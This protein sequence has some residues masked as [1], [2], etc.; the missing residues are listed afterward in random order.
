MFV[1]SAELEAATQALTNIGLTNDDLYLF[2]NIVEEEEEE[3]KDAIK[4]AL[5]EYFECSDEKDKKSLNNATLK[6]FDAYTIRD[7][8]FIHKIN[9]VIKTMCKVAAKFASPFFIPTNDVLLEDVDM[10]HIKC[11]LHIKFDMLPKYGYCMTKIQD[12]EDTIN[13]EANK[14]SYNA[15]YL[16]DELYRISYDIYNCINNY[17]KNIVF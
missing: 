3:E 5:N 9:D 14:S 7:A 11:T 8:E 10:L 12:A 2:E 15:L 13:H 4:S 6:D 17:E 1:Q 16:S